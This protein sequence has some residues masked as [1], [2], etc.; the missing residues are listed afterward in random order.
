MIMSFAFYTSIIKQS[1][2][3]SFLR[4]NLNDHTLYTMILFDIKFPCL[5]SSYT[6]EG[7]LQVTNKPVNWRLFYSF[8]LVAAAAA[9]WVLC[10]P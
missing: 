6:I 7:R 8:V 2:E 5:T 9:F 10:V 1:S 4:A 3:N